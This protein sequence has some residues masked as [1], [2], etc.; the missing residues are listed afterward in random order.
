MHWQNGANAIATTP[1]QYVLLHCRS[2]IAED[3]SLAQARGAGICMYVNTLSKGSAF[4]VF[5]ARAMVLDI[6]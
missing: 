4:P 1:M 3:V 2:D 5:V 6:V